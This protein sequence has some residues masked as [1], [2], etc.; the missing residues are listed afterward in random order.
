MAVRGKKLRGNGI[1]EASRMMLPEHRAAIRTHR[2]KLAERVKPEL[3]EQRVEELARALS[4]ALV[5]GEEM[6][7]TTFGAYEDETCTGVVEK[8]DAIGKYVKLRSSDGPTW[9]PFGDIIHV[10]PARRR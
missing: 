6:S 2:V 8:I 4:E 9:I 1:W 10:A 7:V 3:D 5:T